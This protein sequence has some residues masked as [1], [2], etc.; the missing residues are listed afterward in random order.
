MGRTGVVQH[1]IPTQVCSPIKQRQYRLAQSL[2]PVVQQQLQEMLHAGVITPSVS[3]WSSPVVLV[4]K[5][6]DS[7]R[8][9]VDYRALNGITIKDAYPLP[10]V[11]DTLDSLGG[12]QYFST[13]DMVL[14][15]RGRP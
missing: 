11:D 15:S 12:A 9:C 4:K 1:Q 2:K 3:P 13:L 5:K 8:F 6:D 14:A 7:Y 10:R